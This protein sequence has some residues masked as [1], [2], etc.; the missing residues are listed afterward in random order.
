MASW[1]FSMRT[2]VLGTASVN[3]SGSAALK[4]ASISQGPHSFTAQYG[5]DTPQFID[6]STSATLALNVVASSSLTVSSSLNPATFGI[7]G[8][9]YRNIKDGQ[10]N[11][12]NRLYCVH[13]WWQVH[14][15]RSLGTGGVAALSTNALAV[16]SHKITASFA[17]DENVNASTSAAI[18]QII[19]EANTATVLEVNPASPSPARPRP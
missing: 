4:I 13:R 10:H 6:S 8:H 15:H 14:W 2:T 19:T 3:T 5:G 1:R 17:G 9:P 18:T 12:A 7:P 16:G 11:S